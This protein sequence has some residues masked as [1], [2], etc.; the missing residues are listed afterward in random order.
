M[1]AQPLFRQNPDDPEGGYLLSPAGVLLLVGS[2]AH[3]PDGEISAQ[4]RRNALD[5][6]ARLLGAARAGGFAQGQVVLETLLANG[7]VS[8][9]VKALAQAAVDA[10]GTEAMARIFSEL[11]VVKQND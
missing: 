11:K 6:L 5:V 7:D 8:E 10:A 3:E 4:G 1:T 9:R 2:M